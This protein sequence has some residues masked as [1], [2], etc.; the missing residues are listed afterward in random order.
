LIKF[1]LN[2]SKRELTQIG[3]MSKHNLLTL[4][5]WCGFYCIIGQL[6]VM[7]MSLL[8]LYKDT[9][10]H[11]SFRIIATLAGT[12]MLSGMI[13]RKNLGY[14]SNTESAGEDAVGET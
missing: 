4:T 3:R 7:K 9:L 8:S 5:L 2:H 12:T 13:S 1:E 11:P 10:L 6:T 14:F